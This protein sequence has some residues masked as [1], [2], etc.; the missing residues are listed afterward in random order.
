MYYIARD[1]R[2]HAFPNAHVYASWY[3]DFSGVNIISPEKLATIP[4]GAN[5]T[6]KPATRLVKFTTDPH[7]YVVTAGRVLRPIATEEVAA[8]LYGT[9]W[10]HQVD[11]IVDTF[12]T[13]YTIGAAIATPGDID[14]KGVLYSVTTASDVLP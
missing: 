8:T 6:Y 9:G 1:G 10:N 4:L 5:M 13:D 14:L 12:Y 2:R 11:D 3:A 7:V